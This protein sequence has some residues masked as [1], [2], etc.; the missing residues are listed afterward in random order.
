MT[1]LPEDENLGR[2]MPEPDRLTVEDRYAMA[3][4]T[5]LLAGNVLAGD[6][7]KTAFMIARVAMQERK[8]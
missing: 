8:Q 7:V 6:V 1:N 5:G 4:L 3:A 2:P